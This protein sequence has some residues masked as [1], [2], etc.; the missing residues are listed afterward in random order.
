MGEGN[1]ARKS[2]EKKGQSVKDRYRKKHGELS[3]KENSAV[4]MWIPTG[5]RWLDSIICAGKMAGIPTGKIIEIAGEE[6]TGKSYLGLQIAKN[7]LD[8]GLLVVYLDSEHTYDDTFMTEVGIDPDHN[9]FIHAPAGTVENVFEVIE[10]MTNEAIEM[11]TRVLVI[12][13]SVA[14][15]PSEAE[16]DGDYNPQHDVAVVPRIISRGFKKLTQTMGRTKTTLVALNQLKTKIHT[17]P[18]ARVMAMT[19]P[20]SAPGGKGIPYNASLRIWLTK[21]KAKSAFVENEGGFRIGSE[22]KCRIKKSRFGTE[23]RVCTFQ[24]IWGG[25]NKRVADE[26][27][28]L[29]AIKTSDRFISGAWSCIVN[30]DGEPMYNKFQRSSWLK[31]LENEDFKKTVLEIMDEEVIYK[32]HKQLGNADNFYTLEEERDVDAAEEPEED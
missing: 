13:D 20:W 22:V 21:R 9:M 24:I 32:F 1:M 3:S 2:K 27:S 26:E 23:G 5:S 8:M 14:N 18:N 15:T 6:S 4:D 12:W 7:A 19:D 17:G 16:L 28:W 31:M 30:E 10:D 25:D 11:N 29:E